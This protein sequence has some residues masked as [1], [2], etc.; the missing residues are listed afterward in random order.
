ML[1]FNCIY[2]LPLL[3]LFIRQK[4]LMWNIIEKVT[5]CVLNYL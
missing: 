2:S 4:I 3:V 1:G 5:L